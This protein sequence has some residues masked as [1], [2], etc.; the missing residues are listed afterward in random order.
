VTNP[1]A[2]AGLCAHN[3]QVR[4]DVVGLLENLVGGVSEAHAKL[5]RGKGAIYE[6]QIV[7]HALNVDL[8]EMV[9]FEP[10]GSA[11]VFDHVKSRETRAV[12]AGERNGIGGGAL[13]V[14]T[15]IGYEKNRVEFDLRQIPGRSGRSDGQHRAGGM[16]EDLLSARTKGRLRPDIHTPRPGNDEVDGVFLDQEIDRVPELTFFEQRGAGRR[17]GRNCI[18]EALQ[19]VFR[20]AA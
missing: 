7:P 5:R 6:R 10:A 4:G 18:G 20:G 17:T 2:A 16:T 13:G 19:L 12:F 14:R 9:Q 15:E 8:A 1:A 11:G 3:D